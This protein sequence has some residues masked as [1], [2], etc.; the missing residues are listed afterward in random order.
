MLK[1]HPDLG[2]MD[3][4]QTF[5]F[6]TL[7]Y[8]AMMKMFIKIV[9]SKWEALENLSGQRVTYTVPRYMYSHQCY[10]LLHL[11]NY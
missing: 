7:T 9:V 4:M 3:Q 10:L 11:D 8:S 1:S 6:F 2:H 5:T